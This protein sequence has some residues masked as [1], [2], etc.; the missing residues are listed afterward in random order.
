MDIVTCTYQNYMLG[1][2][3]IIE[4]HGRDISPTDCG[5]R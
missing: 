3:S 4:Y 5:M 1:K 2:T